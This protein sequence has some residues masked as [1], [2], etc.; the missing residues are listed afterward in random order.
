VAALHGLQGEDM[1]CRLL[2]AFG[3]RLLARNVRHGR[4][5]IDVLALE[6]GFLVCI[7]VK[8]RTSATFG[9]PLEFVTRRKRQLLNDALRAEIEQR[10]WLGPSR[11][12]EVSLLLEPHGWRAEV[13]RDVR[14]D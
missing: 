13:Y 3:Y 11:F 9:Q 1:A 7:E 6:G 12:D 2:L 4:A 8:T 14:Y 5:E 10:N